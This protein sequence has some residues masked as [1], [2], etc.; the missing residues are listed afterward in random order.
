MDFHNLYRHGFARVAACTLPIR[1]VQP[2]ANA[3]AVLAQ[4]RECADDGACL[5]VFPELTLTGYSIEDLLMQDTV[6]AATQDAL[7]W[8]VAPDR[9]PRRRARGRRAAGQ[10]EPDLQLRGGDPPRKRPRRGAQV[11][12]ADLP[13]V[14]RAS[15]DRRPATTSPARS[16]WPVQDVPFGSD[17]LFAADDLPGLRAERRDLRGHVGADPAVRRGGAGGR[18]RDRQPVRQP[19]HRGEG[20]GAQAAVRVRLVAAAGRLRLRRRR[21]GR[22]VHRPVLGRADADLRERRAAGRVRALPRGPRRVDRRPRPGLAGAEPAAAGHLR[23]Q[24]PHPR[25][26]HRRVPDGHLRRSRRRTA[27]SACGG[28]SRGSR[29]SRRTRPGSPRT[30]TRRTTSRCPAW[31][32]GCGRSASR[33]S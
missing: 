23:R 22:I 9:R 19:D 7:A 13:R 5:A 8:L 16:G 14:L 27:T 15:P 29:S 30:A 11:V 6:L 4:A 32:S 28:R 20:R 31:S 2:R 10:P 18:D 33:R 21:R 24:P 26:P 12:P 3:E 1:M 25:R 17:L